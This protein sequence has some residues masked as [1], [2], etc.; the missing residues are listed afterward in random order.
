MNLSLDAAV[1]SVWADPA[2]ARSPFKINKA[3]CEN[4]NTSVQTN[5]QGGDLPYFHI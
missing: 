3:G 1:K 5:M 4:M 2:R